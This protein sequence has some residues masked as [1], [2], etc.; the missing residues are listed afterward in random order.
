MSNG[1]DVDGPI[2]YARQWI[3]DD[4]V[5][6]V[7][8]V[9][10]GDY[11]TTGPVVDAFES[12]LAQQVQAPYGVAFSSGTA[13]LHGAYAAAGI[14]P[15][16]EVIVPANTFAATANAALYLGAKPVF[17]DVELDTGNLNGNRLE[18]CISRRTK[19]IVAVH[20]AGLPA[21]METIHQ[22][23]ARWGLIVIEDGAHA[24]GAEYR[25]KPVGALSPLTCFSFHPVKHIATGEGGMVVTADQELARRLRRFRSHGITRLRD[26][27]GS[28]D[29][30]WYYEMQ[31]LGYNYRLTD[32]QAALGMSQ[33]AKLDRFLRRRRELA[34]RY[35]EA[36]ADLKGQIRLP[37]RRADCLSAWHLYVIGLRDDGDGFRR[38]QL[39]DHLR[40]R[41]ILVNVHYLPVYRHPYYQRLGYR[42]GSLSRG[43]AALSPGP[44]AA[45]LL[46]PD[47]W[48]AGAGDRCPAGRDRKD[49]PL[50]WSAALR[51]GGANWR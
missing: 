48:A 21:S 17:A 16:D 9:L 4:D 49:L 45:P 13:A 15:G 46:W 22:V 43:G 36:L 7:A 20:F 12:R 6:A 23:A 1:K 31:E 33:L 50:S 30:G 14:G 19:A 47:R 29:G 18:S 24:L 34:A 10:R 38:K 26:E 35:D 25:G 5:A 27:L 37:G 42:A 32:I 28:D 8:A 2:P 41:G 51:E 40:A 44:F 3:D 39:F 11:L